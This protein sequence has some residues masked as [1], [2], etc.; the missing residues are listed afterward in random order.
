MNVVRLPKCF[1][2]L[3]GYKRVSTEHFCTH[4]RTPVYS[5]HP[6]FLNLQARSMAPSI[7]APCQPRMLGK[8]NA[9][10]QLHARLMA[11][12]YLRRSQAASSAMSSYSFAPSDERTFVTQWPPSH[13]TRRHS[14]EQQCTAQHSLHIQQRRAEIPRRN[15][16][17]ASATECEP[18]RPRPFPNICRCKTE[19]ATLPQGHK[20]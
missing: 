11:L 15:S 5:I 9:T 6:A 20:A 16:R 17:T 18:R 12:L 14:V 4:C 10:L 3:Q 19:R 7:T 2:S 13:A 1:F 8:S